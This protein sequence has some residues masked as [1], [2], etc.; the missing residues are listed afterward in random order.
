MIIRSSHLRPIPSF[1]LPFTHST[2]QLRTLTHDRSSPFNSVPLKDR[3]IPNPTPFVPNTE[4]FLKLIG[5]NLAQYG[6]KIPSWR[7]LFTM[8]SEELKEVIPNPRARRYLQQW[9]EKYRSGR[10]GV[11]GDLKFVK[12][13]VAELRIAQVP[14]SAAF[15]SSS[16]A[17]ISPGMKKIVVNVPAGGSAA[18]IPTVQLQPVKGVKIQ[19]GSTI[20]GPHVLQLKGKGAKIEAKEGLWEIRQGR[21]LDGGERRQ[22]EVRAK[23]RGE[24]RRAATGAAR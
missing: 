8:S 14:Q 19:G 24:E 10:H 1:L 21:K 16:T 5:R 17:T 18:D 9:R 13:G 2:T 4:T 11:G 15:S 23:R 3:P 22:A 12:D 7:S 6:P 20:A